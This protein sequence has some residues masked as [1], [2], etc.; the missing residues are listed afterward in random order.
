[1]KSIIKLNENIFLNFLDDKS[2]KHD[3]KISLRNSNLYDFKI[4]AYQFL[5]RLCVLILRYDD[6]RYIVTMRDKDDFKYN[7]Y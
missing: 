4:D 7:I 1:M 5:C 6:M 2:E 3:Q